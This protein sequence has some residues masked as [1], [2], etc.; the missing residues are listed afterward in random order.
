MK[1]GKQSTRTSATDHAD[2]S[3]A[4]EDIHHVDEHRGGL[5]EEDD[6]ARGE[7]TERW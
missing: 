4:D 5:A 7:E 2:R 1:K 3:A 6:K